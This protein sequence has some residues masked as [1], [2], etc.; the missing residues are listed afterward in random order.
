[1]FTIKK[2]ILHHIHRSSVAWLSIFFF[3]G[4]F[5]FCHT[6]NAVKIVKKGVP[7][8]FIADTIANAEYQWTFPDKSTQTGKVVYFTFQKSGSTTVT[9]KVTKNG[10]TNQIAKPVFVQNS[11]RPTAIPRV[12]VDGE[13]YHHGKISIGR[14]QKISFDSDSVD[15]EGSKEDLVETWWVDGRVQD[16]ASLIHLFRKPGLYAI[17][18]IV[19]KKNNTGLRDEALI[20]VEVENSAP[21]I[22]SIRIEKDSKLKNQ[23]VTISTVANDTD[24]SIERYRFEILEFNQVRLAQ[25]T[26]SNS[27]IFNLEQFPGEHEYF[28]RVTAT[29]NEGKNSSVTS[30]KAIEVSSFIENTPPEAKILL[31][32]GNSG[33]TKMPFFFSVD[34]SDADKDALRY[35]WVISDGTKKHEKFFSHEFN[36]PG[37]K[38]VRLRVTDGLATVEALVDIV[39]SEETIIQNQPP[40]VN[41]KGVLPSTSGDTNTIFKFFAETSDPDNDQV[42]V[43]WK[44][45]DGK[46]FNLENVAYRYQKPGVYTIKLSGTDGK[47]QH[48]DDLTIRVVEAGEPIPENK[49]FNKIEELDDTP[50]ANIPLQTKIDSPQTISQNY[51]PFN[52]TLK[53]ILK[54]EKKQREKSLSIAADPGVKSSLEEAISILEKKI[55]QLDENPFFLRSEFEL[56]FRTKIKDDRD[57]LVQK[58]K[59]ETRSAEKRAVI[60]EEIFEQSIALRRRELGLDKT[61]L[62][63]GLLIT[64][65]ENRVKLLGTELSKKQKENTEKEIDIIEA[66]IK[67]L[68]NNPYLARTL[69]V[70]KR[71]EILL[72]EQE[73]LFE[74]TNNSAKQTFLKKQIRQII[75]QIALIDQFPEKDEASFMFADLTGTPDTKFFFYGQ[76]PKNLKQA[77]FFE[78]ELGKN[79][80]IPGQNINIRYKKPGLYRIKLTVSDTANEANDSITIKIV[81]N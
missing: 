19:T 51:S 70:K 11:D 9:L 44:M 75:N 34:S 21:E 33:T 23:K 74:K 61:V 35:E 77:L 59:A 78:W 31:S 26:E 72:A 47:L 13:L 22:K 32:P 79:I 64:A 71:L 25:V 63:E 62:V 20:Q 3:I 67:K 60:Q 16:K 12:T 1:M 65:K 42:D 15:S 46:T 8:S 41:I 68:K 55:E 24:G 57:I 76:S 49:D 40:S 38:K 73:Q 81:E 53:S 2:S 7:A 58:Y 43:V 52:P 10:S 48:G 4:N 29:D 5:S 30:E 50:S 37:V 39:I 69:A 56:G 66:E 45:G 17:K 18:L 27:A 54:A 6:V 36:T 80:R 14:D 28:A